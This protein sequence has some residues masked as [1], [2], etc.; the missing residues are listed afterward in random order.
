MN[1]DLNGDRAA[2]VPF[3]GPHEKQT[4]RAASK[5]FTRCLSCSRFS[6]IIDFFVQIGVSAG[7]VDSGSIS[8]VRDS[9]YFLIR[10]PSPPN[11][12]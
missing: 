10:P 8:S 7:S 4:G 5:K 3:R 6:Q 1:G 9:D 12:A 11:P 2:S